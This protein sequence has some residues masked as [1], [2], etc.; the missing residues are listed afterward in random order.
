M[1]D[2][3]DQSIEL[4]KI[5]LDHAWAWWKYHAEQRVALIRFYILSLGGVGAAFGLL[6]QQKEYVLCAIVSIFGT[7]FSFCFIRLDTR[8]SDL[9]K[10]GEAA[11]AKEHERM[12]LATGNEA[13][14]LC[15]EAEMQTRYW[16][17]SYGQ[18]MAAILAV[19]I[20]D[21]AEFA[22]QN[23]GQVADLNR[24]FALQSILTAQARL[25]TPGT[26][27]RSPRWRGRGWIAA[28]SGRAPWRFSC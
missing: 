23:I 25:A 11:L 4:E 16:P 12:A 28:R 21:G 26:L 6:H 7:L 22:A 1:P 10:V 8:T 14:R 17:Y 19:L 5:A 20:H 15:A 9:I 27:I 2:E 3:D 13:M 24:H 18:I